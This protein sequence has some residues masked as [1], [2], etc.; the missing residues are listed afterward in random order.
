MITT[1]SSWK[2]KWFLSGKHNLTLT[3][4]ETVDY[5]VRYRLP[6]YCNV[7]VTIH[8]IMNALIV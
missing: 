4:K 6:P 2:D 3:M 5:P 1:M 7:G 8:T